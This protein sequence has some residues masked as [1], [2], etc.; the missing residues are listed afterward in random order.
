M[1]NRQAAA[2]SLSRGLR[3]FCPELSL[4]ICDLWGVMH[5]GIR[6]NEEAVEAIE[7]ARANNVLTV[8]LSNAPRPRTHVRALL[9]KM[10]MPSALTDYIVTS[11]GLAR[12]E[13]RARYRGAKLY[14]MGPESDHNTVDG[15]PV[16]MVKTPDEADI[17]L[18]TDLDFF[19]VES[20]RGWLAGA[21][22]KNVPFLCANPDRV[23]HV[24]EKLYL[25]AGSVADLYTAMGGEVHW[26]GK[27]MASALEA[28]LP[29]IGLAPGS[30]SGEQVMMIG[31]SLQTDMAGAHAAGYRGLFIAG[32]IHRDEYP[33][34]TSAADARGQVSVGRFREIFGAEKAVPHAVM[35]SLVW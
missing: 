14:H 21:A 17:I 26:F 29:E 6:L 4:I 27:P 9:V 34:L 33:V 32:G 1:P 12:D 28:C 2:V 10:G 13:V 3:E 15:L 19:D 18:A 24:G 30:L 11:G 22:K 35:E 31:D 5:D 8:F 20:H 7:K 23:V 16:T 25:C